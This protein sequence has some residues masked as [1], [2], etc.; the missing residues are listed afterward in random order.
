MYNKKNHHIY[1]LFE[2]MLQSSQK[3]RKILYKIGKLSTC[4]LQ[5]EIRPLMYVNVI[6]II[7]LQLSFG[8]YGTKYKTLYLKYCKR[9]LLF[10]Y[11]YT[12]LVLYKKT[13]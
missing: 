6:T 10:K 13:L 5:S 1:F 12:I 8:I 11:E 4:T 2:T 9:Y 3:L 7:K